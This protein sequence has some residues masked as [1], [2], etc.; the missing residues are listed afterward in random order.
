[1]IG[2]QG[3]SKISACADWVER[4]RQWIEWNDAHGSRRGSTGKGLVLPLP[5]PLLHGNRVA[6]VDFTCGNDFRDIRSRTKDH[7]EIF[8]KKT[9]LYH[10][11]ICNSQNSIKHILLWSQAHKTLPRTSCPLLKA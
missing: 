6:F 3:A 9:T 10:K 4:L 2:K 7:Q 5:L 1:L 11:P 8:H